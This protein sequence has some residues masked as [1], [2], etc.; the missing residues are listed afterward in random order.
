MPE[1]Q[2][3]D[4]PGRRGKCIW[5][6]TTGSEEISFDFTWFNWRPNSTAAPRKAPVMTSNIHLEWCHPDS[7]IQSSK[8]YI[9]D[10]VVNGEAEQSVAAKRISL[11]NPSEDMID[12]TPQKLVDGTEWTK[13]LH[14]RDKVAHGI[15]SPQTELNAFFEIQLLTMCTLQLYTVSKFSKGQEGK[16]FCVRPRNHQSMHCYIG[17]ATSTAPPPPPHPTTNELFTVE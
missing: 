1:A 17:Q 12:I 7:R 14:G 6:I 9:Y 5:E 10:Q 8:W 4:A 16:P 3:Q 15:L 11:L 13:G 2:L